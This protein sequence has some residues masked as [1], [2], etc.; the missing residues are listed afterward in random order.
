MDTRVKDTSAPAGLNWRNKSRRRYTPEQR[1]AMVQEC[2][3]PG[4][5]VSEVAQRN[6][7]N[8]NLSPGGHLM[9]CPSAHCP[10]PSTPLARRCSRHAYK[11]PAHFHSVWQKSARDFGTRWQL[12]MLQLLVADGKVS[13]E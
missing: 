4:V 8:T 7:V 1:L 13:A 2:A 12:Q 10:R 11:Q 5:S 6:R 3:A 9:R